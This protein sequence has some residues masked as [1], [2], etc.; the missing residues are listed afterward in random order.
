MLLLLNY[1]RSQVSS[2]FTLTVMITN[3]IH[4]SINKNPNY[5]F[6][7]LN[8]LLVFIWGKKRTWL[9]YKQFVDYRYLY[10]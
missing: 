1:N 6:I 8:C 3:K 10:E 5:N 2:M 4:I 9:V 7:K